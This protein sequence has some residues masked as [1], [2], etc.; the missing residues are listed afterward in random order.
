MKEYLEKLTSSPGGA[1]V[2]LVTLITTFWGLV[3]IQE[4]LA[5]HIGEV[6]AWCVIGLLAVFPIIMFLTIF[7]LSPSFWRRFHLS[8]NE[9]YIHL[10]NRLEWHISTNGSSKLTKR[11]KLLFI[12]PHAKSDLNDTVFSSKDLRGQA[13]DYDSDDAESHDFEAVSDSILRVFWKPRTGRVE[14]GEPY[15]HHNAFEIPGDADSWQKSLTIAAPVFCARFHLSLKSEKPPKRVI[16]YKA[17]RF[18]HFKNHEQIARKAAK[19]KRF[20]APLV[21]RINDGEFSWLMICL[22]PGVTYY[23]VVFYENEPEN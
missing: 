20:D 8:K 5:K 9:R 12:K 3:S 19:L 14:P 7:L 4:S 18:Q 1:V 10:D 6:P 21:K 22:H 13:V 2:Q 11:T 16:V 15:D 23:C 17:R